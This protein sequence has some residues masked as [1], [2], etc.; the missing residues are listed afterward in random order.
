MEKKDTTFVI[1]VDHEDFATPLRVYCCRLKTFLTNGAHTHI[2]SHMTTH[3]LYE[4]NFIGLQHN[5]PV[6]FTAGSA[7]AAL[8]EYCLQRACIGMIFFHFP[9]LL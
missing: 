5:F 8:I 1:R 9:T 7:L 6:L 2:H 3:F 4:I